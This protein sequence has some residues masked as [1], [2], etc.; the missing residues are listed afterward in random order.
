MSR[1]ALF[2]APSH[3]FSMSASPQVISQQVLLLWWL[4]TLSTVA[5]VSSAV[6]TMDYGAVNTLLMF[7]ACQRRSCVDVPIVDDAVLENMESFF[8]TLNKTPSLNTRIMHTQP[9]G[10]RYQ[11]P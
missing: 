9:S 3:S 11:Y 1:I 8:V 4:H 2:H 5:V 7:A 10:W 6:A